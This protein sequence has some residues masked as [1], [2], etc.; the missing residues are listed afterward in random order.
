M[1]ER[2]KIPQQTGKDVLCKD[3]KRKQKKQTGLRKGK[4]RKPQINI[5]GETCLFQNQVVFLPLIH[6][7]S[8]ILRL[9]VR[10][11]GFT[12][13]I[14]QIRHDRLF[15]KYLTTSK[16]DAVNSA[17]TH[18]SFVCLLSYMRTDCSHSLLRI[19]LSY[20]MTF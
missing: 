15:S 8:F 20:N 9:T 6:L 12:T 1:A 18:A 13:K 17:K 3:R 16:A 5:L 4:G 7:I 11:D 19:A 14:L 10:F 2:K